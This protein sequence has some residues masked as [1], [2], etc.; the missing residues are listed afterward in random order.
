MA[1]IVLLVGQTDD[2]LLGPSVQLTK[3]THRI[4]LRKQHVYGKACHLPVEL[5]HK[6]YWALKHTNFDIK[7]ARFSR[8][9]EDSPAL[10]VGPHSTRVH[11]LS[12]ILE[13]DIQ[14]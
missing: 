14:I 8:D 7:T 6:A 2:A 3:N 4:A 5:E 11:I 9:S 12:F 13:I 1:K 10:R